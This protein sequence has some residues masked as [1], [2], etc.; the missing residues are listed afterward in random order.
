MPD[1]TTKPHAGQEPLKPCRSP[2]CECSQ[3]ACTHPGFYDAREQPVSDT[4]RICLGCG[5]KVLP[6][7]DLTCGH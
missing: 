3:G 1:S 2:Y 5:T 7:E 6:G 4:S